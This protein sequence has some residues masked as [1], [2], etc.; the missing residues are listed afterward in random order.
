[1]K[2]MTECLLMQCNTTFTKRGN[3]KYCSLECAKIAKQEKNHGY[4][5]KEH[6]RRKEKQRY[7]MN[8]SVDILLDHMKG[9]ID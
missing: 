7:L 4:H 6:E 3:R 9:L 8:V 1:M 2:I 5:L